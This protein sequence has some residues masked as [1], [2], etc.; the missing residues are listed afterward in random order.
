MIFERAVAELLDQ[1]SA[2]G[3]GLTPAILA[4]GGLNAHGL[5]ACPVGGGETKFGRVCWFGKRPIPQQNGQRPNRRIIHL[6]MVTSTRPFSRQRLGDTLV[7]C[8]RNPA[9]L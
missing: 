8:S 1:K 7:R 6:G 9:V 4:L 2:G 5:H 3:S